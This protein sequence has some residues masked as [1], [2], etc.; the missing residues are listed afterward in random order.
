[1]LCCKSCFDALFGRFS[2]LP[3]HYKRGVLHAVVFL[4]LLEWCSSNSTEGLSSL[5]RLNIGMSSSFAVVRSLFLNGACGVAE[6]V[7]A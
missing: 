6:E 5:K 3:M 4:V 7:E 2:Q 1:M